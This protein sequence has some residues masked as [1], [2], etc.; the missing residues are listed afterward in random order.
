MI[1]WSHIDELKQDMGEA[2]EEVV[3]VFLQEV[4]EGIAKLDQGAPPEALA[5]NLHFLKGAALNL[6]F[7]Q[8]AALCGDGENKANAGQAGSVDLAAVKRSYEV[9]RQE[10]TTGLQRRAA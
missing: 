1:D 5:A 9:S 3:D 2:F 10:F 4:E 6:G 8:F 7:E